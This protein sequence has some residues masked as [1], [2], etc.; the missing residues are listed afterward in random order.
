MCT[1]PARS[2]AA[3]VL[4]LFASLPALKG[5]D[6]RKPLILKHPTGWVGAI[7]FSPDGKSLA[8]TGSDRTVRLWDSATGKL[9]GTLTGHTDTVCAVAFDRPGETLVT[10]S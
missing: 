6:D 8:S 1:H 4:S 10:A 5:A 3:V 2:L 9:Q 7:A